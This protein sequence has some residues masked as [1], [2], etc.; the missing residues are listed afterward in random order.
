MDGMQSQNSDCGV[1]EVGLHLPNAR[2][3]EGINKDAGAHRTS[4][5]K[6]E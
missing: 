4:Y 6:T 3:L 2:R 1:Y 5:Y